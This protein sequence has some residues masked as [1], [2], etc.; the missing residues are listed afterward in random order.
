MAPPRHP[1]TVNA[2][3]DAGRYD[4]T[5]AELA[6]RLTQARDAAGL[7]AADAADRSDID[8][9]RL[10]RIERGRTVPSA[11]ELGRLCLIYQLDPWDALTTEPLD[12]DALID[13]ATAW[14]R[15]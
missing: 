2:M 11:L 9:D 5:R 13:Q 4:L 14:R 15:R 1:A 7:T 12:V 10:T 3:D 6:R 8:E